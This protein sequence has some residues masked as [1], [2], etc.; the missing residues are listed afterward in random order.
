MQWSIGMEGYI[1]SGEE[2]RQDEQLDKTN[3]QYKHFKNQ[4]RYK[5]IENIHKCWSCKSGLAIV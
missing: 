5:Q 4:G 3:E 1:L 2:R